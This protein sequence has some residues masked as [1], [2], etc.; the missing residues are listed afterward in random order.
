MEVVLGNDGP[1]TLA[2][3]RRYI[4][5]RV[6]GVDLITL[7]LLGLLLVSGCASTAIRTWCCGKG[8]IYS[9]YL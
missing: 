2:K 6:F 9:S 8:V 4:C 5:P 1:E 3:Y 7:R